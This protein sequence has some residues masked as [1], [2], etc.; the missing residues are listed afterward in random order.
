[1]LRKSDGKKMEP[2]VDSPK[3]KEREW[4]WFSCK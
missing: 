2:Y 3:V 4:G 1:M